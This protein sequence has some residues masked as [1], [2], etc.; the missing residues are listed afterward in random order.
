MISTAE[1]VQIHHANLLLKMIYRDFQINMTDVLF[2]EMQVETLWVRI[3]S[4]MILIS[5]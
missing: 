3:L 5:R 4:L 1:I 2:F